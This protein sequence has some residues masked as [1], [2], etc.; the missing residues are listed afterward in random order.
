MFSKDALP[1]DF[2]PL[3]MSMSHPAGT[4]FPLDT[5]V[6]SSTLGR[7]TITAIPVLLFSDHRRC[8]LL[9]KAGPFLVACSYLT[10]VVPF[11]LCL[12]H[13]YI[14]SHVAQKKNNIKCIIFVVLEGL[15]VICLAPS[16]E[17]DAPPSLLVAGLLSVT[18]ALQMETFISARLIV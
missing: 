14:V 17:H 15:C 18:V 4:Q 1:G 7:S 8:A 3:K 12:L 16:R 2:L 11:Y 5:T 10:G 9:L 6:S 13:V